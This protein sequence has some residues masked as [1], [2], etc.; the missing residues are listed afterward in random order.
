MLAEVDLV[1]SRAARWGNPFNQP[2]I[3]RRVDLYR[4]GPAGRESWSA[5]G[6][7]PSD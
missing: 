2:V 7:V 4:T 1:G 3:D 6:D 5:P